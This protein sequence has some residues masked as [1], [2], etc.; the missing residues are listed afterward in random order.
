MSGRLPRRS[1]SRGPRLGLI[2]IAVMTAIGAALWF[3]LRGPDARAGAI[4]GAL[5]ALASTTAALTALHLSRA[6]LSRTDQQLA[7]AR[8]VTMLSRHPLLLPVHQSV[9]FPD[10]AGNLAAHPPTTDRFKLSPPRPGSYAFVADTNDTFLV[11]IE[12]LGE[13]PA[14]QVRGTL[15]HHSGRHGPLAGPT[16]VG[17]G[18]VAVFIA[19]VSA[20]TLELPPKFR[21]AIR[22]AGSPKT[23]DLFWLETSYADVFANSLGGEALFDSR[24]VGGWQAASGEGPVD[25]LGFARILG[26]RGAVDGQM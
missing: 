10:S 26:S 25:K 1:R 23:C 22:S 11:P 12:N 20:E 18:R 16:M 2:A 21:E 5:S 7:H 4:A 24:G 6:A 19:R 14:L 15:W 17:S 13:G 8:L 9:S 3:A